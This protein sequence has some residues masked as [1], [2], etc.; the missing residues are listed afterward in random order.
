MSETC[1]RICPVKDLAANS[2]R[3][4]DIEGKA[5]AVYNI[6]GAVYATDDLCTHGLSSLSEG[7][8][9]GDVVE[10]SLHFG[11][12]HVPTGQPAG[13]PCSVALRTYRTE[14]QEGIVH[15]FADAK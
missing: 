6:D 12:F 11:A 13:A 7:T 14:I 8:L 10:C 2:M 1:H 3:K 4:F 15:I 5:I 9:D